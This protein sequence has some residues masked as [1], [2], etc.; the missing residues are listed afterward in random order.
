M[1]ALTLIAFIISL[2]FGEAQRDVTYG[3]LDIQHVQDSLFGEVTE[4]ISQHR[5]WRLYSGPFVF[6]IQKPK[7]P[8]NDLFLISQAV[9]ALLP[10][11]VYG[12]VPT[13]VRT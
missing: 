12:H 10:T 6:L 9:L 4:Q 1:I 8:D 13:S 3:L 7:L 11:L 5:K 2:L